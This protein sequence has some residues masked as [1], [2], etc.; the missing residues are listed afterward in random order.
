MKLQQYVSSLTTNVKR[1]KYL[2]TC[3]YRWIRKIDDIKSEIYEG[4]E[5]AY[6]KVKY[7]AIRDVEK[8]TCVLQYC[9]DEKIIHSA[10]LQQ[11]LKY[12]TNT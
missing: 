6:K 4:Q 11:G 9:L 10:M 7:Y 5:G 12:L 3:L 8:F 1:R 2:L